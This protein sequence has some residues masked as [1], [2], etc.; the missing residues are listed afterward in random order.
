M[1]IN[2]KCWFTIAVFNP[3]DQELEELHVVPGVV[4]GDGNECIFGHILDQFCECEPYLE[5][6]PNTLFVHKHWV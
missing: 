6:A 2:K 4:D 5:P 3:I 1:Q